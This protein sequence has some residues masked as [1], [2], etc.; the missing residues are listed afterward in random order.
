[1]PESDRDYFARRAREERAAAARAAS[2][3]ARASHAG[4]A[5]RYADLA[6]AFEAAG[7]DIGDGG[8]RAIIARVSIDAERK[9]VP[10]PR[11][12]ND[13]ADSAAPAIDSDT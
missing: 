12:P 11:S 2:E 6:G 8:R 7:D 13:S 3:E 5:E 4:L 10:S 1:M 9:A